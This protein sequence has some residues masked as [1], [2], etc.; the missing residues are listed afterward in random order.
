MYGK[1]W[2]IVFINKMNTMGQ[3]GA[4]KKLK[5]NPKQCIKHIAFTISVGKYLNSCT[6]EI[7]MGGSF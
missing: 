6:G 4:D 7:S 1:L 2:K 3:W 5:K